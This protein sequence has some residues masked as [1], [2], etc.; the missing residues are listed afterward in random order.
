MSAI[1]TIGGQGEMAFGALRSRGGGRPT[2]PVGAHGSVPRLGARSVSP[3]YATG[4]YSSRR[5][6]RASYDLPAFRYIAANSHPG[7]DTL[8]AFRKRF[9][10]EIES[11][12]VQVLGIAKTR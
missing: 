2:W 12:F 5:I 8:C 10:Y 3:D 6:E 7:H 1:R 4:T 11:L 9:A